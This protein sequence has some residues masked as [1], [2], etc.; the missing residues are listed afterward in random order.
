MK[1]R[2]T[3][4][5]VW[6]INGSGRGYCITTNCVIDLNTGEVKAELASE[7][8]SENVEVLDR[9]YIEVKGNQF[10][11]AE[12]HITNLDHLRKTLILQKFSGKETITA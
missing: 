8:E 1:I 10:A 6:D 3:Y 4:N 12:D 5:T 11:V 2:G 7:E 9:E